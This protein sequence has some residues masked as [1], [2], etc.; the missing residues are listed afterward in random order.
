MEVQKERIAIEAFQQERRSCKRKKRRRK[1]RNMWSIASFYR[2]T[3]GLDGR[4]RSGGRV[5]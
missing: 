3:S 5:L 1:R 2:H 4:P